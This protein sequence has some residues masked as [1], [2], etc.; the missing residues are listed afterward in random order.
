ML[1]EIPIVGALF[2]STAFQTDKS[3]LMFVVTPRLVKPMTGP[4][5]LPTDSYIEPNRL[6]LFLGGKMEGMP[7]EA[8]PTA[9]AVVPPP[10]QAAPK[11][12]SG[13]ETK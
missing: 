4:T 12:P 6:D 11:G 10:A 13:F 3:E 8:S 9:P 5:R 2:R 1:G 7:P